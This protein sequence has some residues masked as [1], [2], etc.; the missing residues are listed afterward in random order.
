MIQFNAPLI[1]L[2]AALLLIP[3]IEKHE[4]DK[5]TVSI[6][7]SNLRNDKGSVNLA[8]F[9]S[10]EGFPNK[11]KKAIL[12]RKSLIEGEMVNF[13]IKLEAGQYAISIIHDENKNDKLDTNWLGLP[14]EGAAVSNNAYS[15]IG[16]PK[17]EKAKFTLKDQG[18]WQTL[19]IIYF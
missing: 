10:K 11:P 13:N 3:L 8:V 4:D 18:I 17:Y 5:F 7:V 9:A 6:E 2:I 14:K 15:L 12:T 16:P 1:P 19:R